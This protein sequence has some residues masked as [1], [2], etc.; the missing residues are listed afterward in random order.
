MADT[1]GLCAIVEI[2]QLKAR[3]FRAIDTK[4]WRLL[5]EQ[6]T[7]D[8]VADF[9]DS[10]G[11]ADERL[12]THGADAFIASVQATLAG[13]TTVHH[14]HTPEITLAG[15]REARAIWAMDDRLWVAEGSNLPFRWLHG[16]GH[17]HDCYRKARGRWLIAAT[18]LSRIR[19]ETG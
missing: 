4:D 12:L 5:R 7:D 11:P 6:V 19:V 16:F 10:A 2:K 8:L 15:A 1:E 9:R 14:G 18:R 3:Y 13:V 17:Y